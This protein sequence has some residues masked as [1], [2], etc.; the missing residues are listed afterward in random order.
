MVPPGAG[1]KFN[2][3]DEI[4]LHVKTMAIPTPKVKPA[5]TNKDTYTEYRKLLLGAIRRYE[6]RIEDLMRPELATNMI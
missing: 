4:Y 2:R 6:S 1:T 3:R 5:T